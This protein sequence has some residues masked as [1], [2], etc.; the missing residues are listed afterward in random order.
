MGGNV[1]Y[2]PQ[3]VAVGDAQSVYDAAML[4][5]DARLAPPPD[6]LRR[7]FGFIFERRTATHPDSIAYV[8]DS[9]TIGP[10]RMC[11][12]WKITEHPYVPV[13]ETGPVGGSAGIGGA[14]A[15][16]TT[17]SDIRH[18]NGGAAEAE[19][20]QFPC[21]EKSYTPVTPGSL[22]TPLNRH[23]DLAPDPA[24]VRTPDPTGSAAPDSARSSAPDPPRSAVPD[25]LRSR[26]I[27][28]IGRITTTGTV[29]EFST[30][31]RPYGINAGSADAL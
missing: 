1:D 6:I 8:Y 10:L 12:A 23:P 24:R 4:A 15:R 17:S 5:Y 31:G 21:T 25:S 27:P 29:T 7:T 2:T 19:T 13:H 11:K 16:P 30:S 20:V 3:R 28:K 26:S 14:V 22:T 9:Y 18:D